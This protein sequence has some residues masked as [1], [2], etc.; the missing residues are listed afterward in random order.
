MLGIGPCLPLFVAFKY[1]TM[2]KEYVKCAA[3]DV[4]LKVYF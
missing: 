3:Q 4:C 2:E 1:Y